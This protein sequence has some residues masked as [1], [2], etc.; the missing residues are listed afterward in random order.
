VHKL[1]KVFEECFGIL[2]S[3]DP[4][5]SLGQTFIVMLSFLT[6]TFPKKIIFTA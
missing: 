5:G 2:G 6:S 3:G 4:T 1:E